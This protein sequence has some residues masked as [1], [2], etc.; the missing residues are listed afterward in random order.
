MKALRLSAVLA[1]VVVMAT[2]CPLGGQADLV[3]TLTVTGTPT[4]VGGGVIA[5]PVQVVVTNQGDGSATI[6]KVSTE[7]TSQ[8]GTFAVSFSVPFQPSQWYP[9]TSTSL[10]AGDSVT[11]VGTVNFIISGET[12]DLRAIADSCSGDEFMPAYCR[13]NESDETNNVSAD[14]VVVLP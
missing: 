8:S 10:A 14:V 12:V 7:Y 13:V 6:F 11:F 4:N 9:Y 3:A 2:G 1:A 5:V